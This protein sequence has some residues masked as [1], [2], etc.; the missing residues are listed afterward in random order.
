M[1]IFSDNIAPLFVHSVDGGENWELD[2][3][4]YM[5]GAMAVALSFPIATVGYAV[6]LNTITQ[7]ASI[8]KYGGL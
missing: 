7:S 2:L 1:S 6:L 3:P 8:A 5:K 4:A